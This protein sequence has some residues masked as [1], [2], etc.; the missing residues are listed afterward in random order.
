MWT[1]GRV[2]PLHSM[3]ASSISSGRYHGK[4]CWWDLIRSKQLSSGSVYRAPVFAGF[5]GRGKSIYN[6]IRLLKKEKKS[7]IKFLPI[8]FFFFFFFFFFGFWIWHLTEPGSEA[9]IWEMWVTFSLLLLPGPLWFGEVVPVMHTSLAKLLR[10][11]SHSILQSEVSFSKQ[12]EFIP[13]DFNLRS[14][15]AFFLCKICFL[16]R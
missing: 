16:N 3:V 11:T 15:S 12:I 13:L 5:S 14:R 8:F 10:P 1:S 2:S 9:P 7:K 4:H 6:I